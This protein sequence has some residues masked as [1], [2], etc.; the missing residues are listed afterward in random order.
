MN[1]KLQKILLT[2]LLSVISIPILLQLIYWII[3]P[4]N[5]EA[6]GVNDFG[7]GFIGFFVILLPVWITMTFI[8]WF[9]LKKYFKRD[10]I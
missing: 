10:K 4:R 2:I 3:L 6:D 7:Y 5:Y 9:L 1:K 8:I